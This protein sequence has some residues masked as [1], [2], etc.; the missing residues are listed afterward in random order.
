MRNVLRKREEKMSGWSLLIGT[1]A[2]TAF[3]PSELKNILEHGDDEEKRDALKQTIIMMVN[4]DPLPQLLMV[5][6][7]FVM[8]S[9]DLVLRKLLML[10]LEVVPKTTPDGKLLR[11]IYF[12]IFFS[13]SPFS[14]FFPSPIPPFSNSPFSHSLLFP[15]SLILSFP[16]SLILSFPHSLIPSFSHSLILSFPHSLIPSF[17]HS[18]I[19]SFPHSPIPILPSSLY[20]SHTPQPVK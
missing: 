12:F 4:G 3:T 11:F 2:S 5:I 9:K 17:S 14:L 7:R 19:L 6:I 15:H 16:H 13:S 1:S 10:Y 18:L 20:F 8:P